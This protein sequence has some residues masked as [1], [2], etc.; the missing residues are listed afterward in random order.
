MS[1]SK[2]ES[3][4]RRVRLTEEV[5]ADLSDEEIDHLAWIL[6]QAYLS[7]QTPQEAA[8]DA[9]E[10]IGH[11]APMPGPI[12]E[13]GPAVPGGGD[14]VM[15]EKFRN[16]HERELYLASASGLYEVAPRASMSEIDAQAWQA[17]LAYRARCQ[18]DP[19]PDAG[20]TEADLR[21]EV[22]HD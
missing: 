20:P 16:E 5:L 3:K 11:C 10:Y 6:S 4:A 18:P 19:I 17:V 15:S 14:S 8:V 22:D 1:K 9:V 21:G 12:P 2:A 13:P 7:G